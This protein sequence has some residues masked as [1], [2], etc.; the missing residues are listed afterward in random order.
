[1]KFTLAVVVYVLIGLVL[2]WGI[3][4]LMKGSYWLLIVGLVAYVVA[5]ARIGCSNH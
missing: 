3:L 5:F 1:M 2:S 4:A